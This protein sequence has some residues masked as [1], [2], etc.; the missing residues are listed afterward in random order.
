MESLIRNIQYI[1]ISVCFDGSK[2][3][4]IC[5]ALA[6]LIGKLV[7]ETL[8]PIYSSKSCFCFLW[9]IIDLLFFFFA[10]M[11]LKNFA[12]GTT[13][14]ATSITPGAVIARA[15]VSANN[16]GGLPKMLLI[17]SSQRSQ[18]VL[19]NGKSIHLKPF[20]VSIHVA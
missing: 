17:N 3:S 5:R 11:L 6:C 16:G 13:F 15:F 20:E 19:L 12:V 9:F 18:S 4:F 7:K 8:E 2:F 1:A 10:R 14:Y